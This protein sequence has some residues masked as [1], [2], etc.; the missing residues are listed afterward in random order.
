[1]AFCLHLGYVG[2]FEVIISNNFIKACRIVRLEGGCKMCD[3]VVL[4]V[5]QFGILVKCKYPDFKGQKSYVQTCR[6]GFEGWARGAFNRALGDV[7]RKY[8]MPEMVDKKILNAEV[9][10]AFKEYIKEVTKPLDAEKWLLMYGCQNNYETVYHTDER[11]V[12]R[13]MSGIINT[14][15]L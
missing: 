8:P 7:G 3:Y 12:G 5:E 11:Q 2:I 10:K 4:K 13:M 14:D 9:N 1:M 6:N 15:S